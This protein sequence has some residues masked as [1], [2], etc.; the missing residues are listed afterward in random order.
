MKRGSTDF[1]FILSIVLFSMAYFSLFTFLPNMT[2]SSSD[3]SDL[4]LQESG[5][6]S[7]VLVKSPGYPENWANIN[8]ADKLGFG[9]YNITYYPN[10]LDNDK[11]QSLTTVTCNSLRAKTDINLNFS[12]N[13]QTTTGFNCT[14]TIPDYARRIDRAV[15]TFNGTHYSP[16]VFQLYVW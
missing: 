3:Q 9:Y 11:V 12:I 13:V 14:G 10:I 16:A 2:L 8:N 6:L 7:T 4:L 5:Y 1:D 15:Y